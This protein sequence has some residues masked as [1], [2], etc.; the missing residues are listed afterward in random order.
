[1]TDAV[2]TLLELL[3][4]EVN[5]VASDETAKDKDAQLAHLRGLIMRLLED[6]KVTNMDVLLIQ[7]IRCYRLFAG[8]HLPPSIFF[9]L[10][11]YYQVLLDRY[12]RF[13]W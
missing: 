12:Q 13:R 9:D 8:S 11:T 5:E 6:P 10:L 4:Y 1:M 7:W 2:E 3:L